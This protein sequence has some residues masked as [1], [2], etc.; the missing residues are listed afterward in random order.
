[1]LFLHCGSY[2]EW[3][4]VNSDKTKCILSRKTREI[5]WR[6]YFSSFGDFSRGF[7]CVLVQL[8]LIQ[9]LFSMLFYIR[10]KVILS[11]I[12]WYDYFMCRVNRL[13]V[14]VN[15]VRDPNKFQILWITVSCSAFHGGLFV[16]LN[17]VKPARCKR[18]FYIANRNKRS[19]FLLTDHF[20]IDEYKLCNKEWKPLTMVH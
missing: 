15:F 17:A 19:V 16:C 8:L 18:Y 5:Q 9:T 4:W 14:M 10:K 6:R 13:R 3:Y 12:R 1:M 20:V 7:E 2:L 11:S